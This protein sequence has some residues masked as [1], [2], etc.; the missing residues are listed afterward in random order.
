MANLPK[1][2]G[3]AVI[4]RRPDQEICIGNNVRVRLVSAEKDKAVIA[5]SAP[6][7]L[8]VDRAERIDLAPLQKEKQ[9][10]CS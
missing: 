9:T 7:D 3:Y 5:I 4:P 2:R 1:I 6:R 8:S 10:G